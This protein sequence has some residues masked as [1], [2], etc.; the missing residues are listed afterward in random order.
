M[1]GVINPNDTQTLHEQVLAA[2]RADYQ[3]APGDPVP[4]EASSTFAAPPTASSQ[5]ALTSTDQPSPTL[6][7]AAIAGI[8]VGGILFLALCAGLLFFLARK[9][10]AGR[11][12]AAESAHTQFTQYPHDTMNS[13]ISPGC[14]TGFQPIDTPS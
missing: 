1:V 10:R 4:N 3:L 2:A 6:S 14:Y 8:T 13:P 11:Q 9:A 7:T 5:G 12:T